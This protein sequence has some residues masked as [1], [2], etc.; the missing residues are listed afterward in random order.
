MWLVNDGG[1]PLSTPGGRAK[2]FKAGTSTP[3]TVYSDIDLTVD[4]ALGPVVYT[5]ELGYLPAI[6]LKTDRLYKVIVEQKVNGDP[7]TWKTLW[8]VDNVGFIDAREWTDDGAGLAFASSISDLKDVDFSEYGKVLVTGYYSD[9]DWGEPSMFVWDG[10]NTKTPEDG[11]YVLPNSRLVSQP[12]RWVQI[13]SGDI[14]DVRK[15]GAIPDMTENSDIQGKVVNAIHYSQENSTRTRPITVGFVAPGRYDFAGAFDFSIYNF[16]DISDTSVHAVKFLILQGVTFRNTIEATSTITLSK[17][18]DCRTTEELVVG[19]NTLLSVEGGGSIEVDP[20]WWGTRPAAI[21][22]CYVKCGSVTTNRKTLTR[23]SVVSDGKMGGSIS[24]EDM[25]FSEFWLVPD[26]DYSSPSTTFVLTDCR[27]GVKDCR[28]ANSYIDI[29]NNQGEYDYG[30]LCGDTVSGKTLPGDTYAFN[31]VFEGVHLAGSKRHHLKDVSGSVLLNNDSHEL[32]MEGC[33]IEI[34]NTSNV[35]VSSLY[36]RDSSLISSVKLILEG[37]ELVDCCDSLVGVELEVTMSGG[38]EMKFKDCELVK[39]ITQYADESDAKFRFSIDG[40]D[41]YRHHLTSSE[42]SDGIVIGSWTHN[43]SNTE[44]PIVVDGDAVSAGDNSHGYIYEGNTGS[45]L[46]RFPKVVAQYI[47]HGQSGTYRDVVPGF[48]TG[49]LIDK[50]AI[51]QVSYESSANVPEGNILA[52]ALVYVKNLSSLATRMFTVAP[53]AL[54]KWKLTFVY[55]MKSIDVTD[56][57]EENAVPYDLVFS[58]VKQFLCDSNPNAGIFNGRC[59]GS[60]LNYFDKTGEDYAENVSSVDV[61]LER[62]E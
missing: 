9:G 53:Q 12:G 43:T 56:I 32:V 23:C 42:P 8:E 27:Y 61:I 16:T 54:S 55:H 4:D 59:A 34:S 18:T 6:W 35:S 5:N 7:E 30:D 11:A 22:D 31:G 26:Y 13:L 62:I 58:E 51:W 41:V 47:G 19:S 50:F 3:E 36:L 14:L 45:F 1:K 21:T 60:M 2:F 49:N 15:F 57:D 10:E 25:P 48:Y 17:E 44:N 33:D 52:Q 39:T 46:P 37:S 40:C 29:R 20:A 24:M 28:S 38:N